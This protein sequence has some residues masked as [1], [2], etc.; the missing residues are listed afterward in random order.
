[1]KGIVNVTHL[2]VGAVIFLA[3][4]VVIFYVYKIVNSNQNIITSNVHD[5]E[6]CRDWVIQGCTKDSAY[7]VKVKINNKDVTMQQVCS[8]EYNNGNENIWDTN[9]YQKCKNETC[10][11]FCPT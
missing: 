1:M 3:V 6:L 8:K 7:D 9:T 4:L 11:G 5:A 10:R 2:L